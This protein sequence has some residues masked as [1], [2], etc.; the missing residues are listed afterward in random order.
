MKSKQFIAEEEARR[1][2]IEQQKQGTPFSIGGHIPQ[3]NYANTLKWITE[4]SRQAAELRMQEASRF[5]TFVIP[6]ME[7]VKRAPQ[8]A[9]SKPA[10]IGDVVEDKGFL[11][12]KIVQRIKRIVGV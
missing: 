2:E 8:V 1:F 4:R 12:G 7:P 10:S 5:T 9:P 3:T 6:G 11:N